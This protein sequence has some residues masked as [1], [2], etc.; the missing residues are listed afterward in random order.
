MTHSSGV[1]QSPGACSQ[2]VLAGAETLPQ[3]HQ[4]E[5]PT[6]TGTEPEKASLSDAA[7][8]SYQLVIHQTS[9]T[10]ILVLVFVKPFTFDA[11]LDECNNSAIG[12]VILFCKREDESTEGP[13]TCRGPPPAGKCCV[14]LGA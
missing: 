8:Q 11:S 14:C 3:D 10:G 7:A 1:S 4:Q 13:L 6:R 12:T 9:A 5:I 2:C